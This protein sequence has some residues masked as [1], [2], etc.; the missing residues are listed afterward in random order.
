MSRASGVGTMAWAQR[1]GGRLSTADQ[2][3]LVG[4]AIG[5]QLARFPRGLARRLGLP[6]RT[7]PVDLAAL[8]APDSALARAA[9]RALDTTSPP[10]LV[11]HGYRSYAWGRLL[12]ARDGRKLD[13]ELFYISCLLHDLGLVLEDDQVPEGSCCFAYDG[14]SAAYQ[15]MTEAGMEA[16]RADA[17]AEAI[18]LHL[19]VKV[20]LEHGAE[21]KYLNAATALDVIGLGKSRIPR[22]AI[23][24]VLAVHPR[25][26]FRTEVGALLTEEARTRKGG[27]T[28]FLVSRLAFDRRAASANW[29]P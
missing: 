15:T 14:A 29:S 20:G 12:A 25:D 13:D 18:C 6:I 10:S 3:R 9:E 22:P 5:L 17:M 7:A 24:A 8:A 26:N 27:R 1:T 2:L 19:N 16:R 21:A 28:D 4:Q 23:E 11:H